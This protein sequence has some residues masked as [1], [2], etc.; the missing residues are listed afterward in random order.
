MKKRPAPTQTPGEIAVAKVKHWL[1]HVC[2]DASAA[3]EDE[4]QTE[5]ASAAAAAASA[6][7]AISASAT[8]VARGRDRGTP[9]SSHPRDTAR[10]PPLRC[11]KGFRAAAGDSACGPGRRPELV[12]EPPGHEVTVVDPCALL[13]PETFVTRAVKQTL[14]SLGEEV[15]WHQPARIHG[16]CIAVA[17]DDGR[18]A[19]YVW[20]NKTAPPVVNT[21]RLAVRDLFKLSDGLF[22]VTPSTLIC[23]VPWPSDKFETQPDELRGLNEAYT[24]IPESKPKRARTR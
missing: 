24:T 2:P 7:A 23:S 14:E 18:R 13:I 11:G 4:V 12:G 8:S 3:V 20:R 6:S 1:A 16:R 22:L 9:R 10:E 5:P 19:I 15:G 21:P 17:T